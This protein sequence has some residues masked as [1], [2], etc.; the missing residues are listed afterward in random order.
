MNNILKIALT[1]AGH[2]GVDGVMHVVAPLA[3]QTQPAG[4]AGGDRAGIV[5]VRLRDQ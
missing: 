4:R 2:G 5:L 1:L 3:V